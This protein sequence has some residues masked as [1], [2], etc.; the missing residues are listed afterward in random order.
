[1]CFLFI[2]FAFFNSDDWI[3]SYLVLCVLIVYRMFSF[4]LIWL[5]FF[6]GVVR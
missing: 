6:I 4:L 3:F 5:E 2:F 1:M